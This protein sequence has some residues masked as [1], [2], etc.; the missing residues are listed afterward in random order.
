MGVIGMGRPGRAVVECEGENAEGFLGRR[1]DA[2]EVGEQLSGR[3]VWVDAHGVLRAEQIIEGVVRG[4]P[5]NDDVEFPPGVPVVEDDRVTD[6]D[7]ALLRGGPLTSIV[8]R[9]ASTWR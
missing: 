3:P 7:G 1:V 9:P 6:C 2:A 4:D 8:L 5:L